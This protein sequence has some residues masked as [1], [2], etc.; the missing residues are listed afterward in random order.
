MVMTQV[1]GKLFTA[2][3]ATFALFAFGAASA[4]Q[5][6]LATDSP[7]AKFL[8]D[9][10]RGDVAEIKLG[11]LAQQKGQSEGV[12][13]FGKMLEED[14]SKAGKKTAELAKDLDVIPPAQPS[15][16]QMQKYDALARLSG[17]EFDGEFAAEMVKGH[18][19]EIA[20]YEKQ[21]QSANNPKV[22]KLAEDTLPTLKQ[23]LAVAQGLQSGAD[24]RHD[25][26]D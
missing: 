25:Q 8:M 3:A 21:A 11:Q 13:E 6:A 18:Q 4:Q 23:H 9:A 1:K 10:A 2:L 26:H 22:A 20:K 14:H 12:R 16:E 7:D 15:A 19:E 5:V 24:V 17:A